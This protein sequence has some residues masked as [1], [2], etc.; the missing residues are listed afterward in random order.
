MLAGAG[1]GAVPAAGGVGQVHGAAPEQITL[2]KAQGGTGLIP[3]VLAQLRINQHGLGV[4]GRV[5]GHAGVL[6]PCGRFLGAAALGPGGDCLIKAIVVSMP[7]S[8]VGQISQIEVAGQIGVA[9]QADQRGPLGVVLD[10]DGHPT[11]LAPAGV[12]A[13]GGVPGHP[14][15]RAGGDGARQLLVQK[16]RSQRRHRHLE[17]GQVHRASLPGAVAMFQRGEHG[18]EGV[19]AGEVI[20][21]GEGSHAGRFLVG[22]AGQ[23]VQPDQGRLVGPPRDVL[24]V[25]HGRVRAEGGQGDVDE[26]GKLRP[27]GGL[28]ESQV[29]HRGGGV[30]GQENVRGGDQTF[31]CGQR[32]R[33]LE[34][35]P[36]RALV[37]VHLR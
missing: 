2:G 7:A 37:G 16:Q 9:Q 35:Q 30:V 24:V 12:H 20:R 23:L 32:G 8:Q 36:D 18:G 26:A 21:R 25:G 33:C 4:V 15:A 6:Q 31:G 29:R 22:K 34:V 10:A 3:A 14:V 27:Q 19:E 13:L 11:V 1:R 17:L 28:A 5:G